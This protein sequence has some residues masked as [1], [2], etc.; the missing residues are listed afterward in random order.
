MDHSRQGV[1]E[2]RGPEPGS[3][4]LERFALSALNS[5]ERRPSGDGSS[6]VAIMRFPGHRFRGNW[7]IRAEA[8]GYQAS[9][10]LSRDGVRPLYALKRRHLA[11]ALELR[12]FLDQLRREGWQPHE[13]CIHNLAPTLPG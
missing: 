13:S 1:R 9:L 3:T 10:H 6:L 8:G 2:H 4:M 5:M 7:H 12:Q 11:S